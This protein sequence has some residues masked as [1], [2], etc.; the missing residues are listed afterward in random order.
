V[1]HKFVSTAAATA[2]DRRKQIYC[3]FHVLLLFN[4][5]KHD[6]SKIFKFAG[7]KPILSIYSIYN[8]FC[9]MVKFVAQNPQNRIQVTIEYKLISPLGQ[10]GTLQTFQPTISI[11]YALYSEF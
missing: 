1:G 3:F 10:K 9:S 5:K 4:A 7:V 2:R 6:L 11:Y 8:Q